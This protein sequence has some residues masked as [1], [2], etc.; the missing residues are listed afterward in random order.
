MNGHE[1]SRMAPFV[2]RQRKHKVR[3][4]LKSKTR[5]GAGDDPNVLELPSSTT[6]KEEKRKAIKSALRAQQP[7]MSSRKQKRLDNYIVG[8]YAIFRDTSLNLSGQKIEKRRDHRADQEI[9][10]H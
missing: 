3:Q 10:E 7:K 9:R 8:I 1:S 6:Q 4:R 2:P 5:E